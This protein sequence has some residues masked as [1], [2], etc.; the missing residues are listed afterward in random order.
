ML[1]KFEEEIFKFIIFKTIAEQ[2]QK[3]SIYLNSFFVVL[4]C[5]HRFAT[6]QSKTQNGTKI[7][8]SKIV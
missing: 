3:K 5:S 8:F 6:I 7:L 2:Q 1:L 4:Y